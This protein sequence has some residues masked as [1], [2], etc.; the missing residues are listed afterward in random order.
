MEILLVVKFDL[1]RFLDPGPQFCGDLREPDVRSFSG[2]PLLLLLE[3]SS[4][5][6]RLTKHG[7]DFAPLLKRQKDLV[8]LNRKALEY[9]DVEI[10]RVAF[11]GDS[12]EQCVHVH[13]PQI[14]CDVIHNTGFF[15]QI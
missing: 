5:E 11:N 3:L 14:V 13:I 1:S 2:L 10:I 9:G 7:L 6:F 8:V 15:F 4:S 12:M